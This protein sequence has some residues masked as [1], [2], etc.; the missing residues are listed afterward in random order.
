MASTEIVLSIT[1]PSAALTPVAADDLTEKFREAVA[2]WLLER[3]S[4]NTRTAYRK[5]LTR[6]CS[7][8]TARGVHPLDA[9][10]AQI[11]EWAEAMRKGIDKA[12][13]DEQ[14]PKPGRK[15]SE[16]TIARCLS[17]VSSFFAYAVSIGLSTVNPV[18]DM[19]RPKRVIDEDGIVFL[20]GDSA[21]GR[22]D[23][24]KAFLAAAA[25]RKGYQAARDHALLAVMLTTGARTAEVL[26]A[27]VSDLGHTGGHRVL[28]VIRKGGKKQALILAPWVGALI[29]AY[30]DGRTEGPL[31]ATTARGGG[32][33]RMDEPALLR[34]IRRVG[35]AAGLPHAE[36]LHP[37][38]LRHSALTAAF[39]AGGSL[40]DV[41]LMA[42]HADPRTTERYLHIGERLD[43]S[44]IHA[45]AAKLAD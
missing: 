31:F 2:G 13:P 44:P 23:E 10:R 18:K 5:D 12:P 24:M 4:P 45:L 1:D 9:E 20:N 34:M 17:V 30:L 8:F 26:G 11:A 41:Q 35:K 42:G 14:D 15:A 22:P 33:G 6:F 3:P 38:S 29:D 19:R 25:V 37:H 43:S 27:D 7:Y 21:A 40:L 39:G 16:S 36:Q 28:F 32:H